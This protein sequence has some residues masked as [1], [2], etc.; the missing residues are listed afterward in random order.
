MI[1]KLKIFSRRPAPGEKGFTLIEILVIIA[2]L[3]LLA[4][5]VIPNVVRFIDSGEQDAR[6]TER[7]NVQIAV[8]SLMFEAGETEVSGGDLD[9]EADAFEITA[10]ADEKFHRLS[11]Y[12]LGYDGE[13]NFLQVYTVATNGLVTLDD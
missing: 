11:E 6:D 4:G 10:G 5:I 1:N 9:A 3:G 13:G 2:I 8:I 7:D 12:L